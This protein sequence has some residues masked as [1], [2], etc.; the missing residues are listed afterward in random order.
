[1]LYAHLCHLLGQA[2]L[3]YLFWSIV[4]Y[5]WTLIRVYKFGSFSKYSAKSS[6]GESILGSF[7]CLFLFWFL[8]LKLYFLF[9]FHLFFIS[10]ALNRKK[11]WER[12]WSDKG[13]F[14][15]LF[16]ILP[17]GVHK[18]QGAPCKAKLS[19][20]TELTQPFG[21]VTGTTQLL[22]LKC[23]L[24]G[25]IFITFSHYHIICLKEDLH[26]LVSK[27]SIFICKKHVGKGKWG[28]SLR[29]N[30]IT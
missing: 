12:R 29:F 20:C 19:L 3:A 7:W 25:H 11:Q 27:H 5:L 13:S 17:S 6:F 21:V 1:M 18:G 28:M 2:E 30:L 14:S 26:L 4:F 23:V 9:I 10:L 15:L 8:I 22:R 24:L 16:F